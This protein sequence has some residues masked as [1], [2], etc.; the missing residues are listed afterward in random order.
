M[1]WSHD[2]GCEQPLGKIGPERAFCS[3]EEFSMAKYAMLY[4]L[5]SIQVPIARKYQEENN[6]G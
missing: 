1:D 3:P 2:L 5:P 4:I 6:D